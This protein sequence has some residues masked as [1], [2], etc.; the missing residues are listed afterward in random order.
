MPGT[1]KGHLVRGYG[2]PTSKSGSH[3]RKV[4]CVRCGRERIVRVEHAELCSDCQ[5]VDPEFGQHPLPR[6]A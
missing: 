1:V 2:S 3:N 4:P 5:L 6:T